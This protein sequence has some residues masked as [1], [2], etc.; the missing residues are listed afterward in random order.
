M[1]CSRRFSKY[2]KQLRS[3]ARYGFLSASTRGCWKLSSKFPVTCLQCVGIMLRCGLRAASDVPVIQ[4]GRLL[5][6]LTD[7]GKS[8]SCAQARTNADRPIPSGLPRTFQRTRVRTGTIKSA[9]WTES[10]R[11]LTFRPTAP[12]RKASLFVY[13]IMWEAWAYMHHWC[14]C[15]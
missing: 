1:L 9:V 8:N 15:G 11:L 3:H 4:T 12:E 10:L 5:Q 7:R 2:Q 6:I 14:C 13:R